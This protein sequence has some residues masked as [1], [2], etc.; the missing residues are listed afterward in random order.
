MGTSHLAS[1]CW[2]GLSKFGSMAEN[3]LLQVAA[4]LMKSEEFA[5][6]LPQT[7]IRM[8]KLTTKNKRFILMDV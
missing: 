7:L 4:G 5:F 8:L 3:K 6:N 1:Q 2:E